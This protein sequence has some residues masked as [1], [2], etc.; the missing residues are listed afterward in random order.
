MKVLIY[1]IIIASVFVGCTADLNVRELDISTDMVDFG[2]VE[3]NKS[4]FKSVEVYNNTQKPLEIQF[5]FQNNDDRDFEL[6]TDGESEIV[7]PDETLRIEIKLRARNLGDKTAKLTLIYNHIG[8]PTKIDIQAQCI[9]HDIQLFPYKESIEFSNSRVHYSSMQILFFKNVGNTDS[10]IESI[11]FASTSCFNVYPNVF[12]I[13]IPQSDVVMVNLYFKPAKAG[14]TE[15][16]MLVKIDSSNVP[17]EIQLKGRGVLPYLNELFPKE[18]FNSASL[19]ANWSI[20]GENNCWE[21]GKPSNGSGLSAYSG[22]YCAG[23]SIASNYPDNS[24]TRLVSPEVDLSQSITP[25]LCFVHWVNT[26]Y[27][28]SG[29]GGFVE[30]RTKIPGTNE[31]SEWEQLNVTVPNYSIEHFND[32]Y[33]GAFG[34]AAEDNSWRQV[35]IDLGAYNGNVI[36]VAWHFQ[37]DSENNLDGWY[38]DDV[39]IFEVRVNYDE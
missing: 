23:T 16:T 33:F 14:I 1:F 5:D 8:S 36:Q 25:V 15:D 7:L 21:V 12:P 9:K 37:S 6:I 35:S 10:S 20:E 2:I 4:S 26:F 19:P 34:G 28:Q 27:D 22:S 32:G 18:S 38:I 3:V 39:Y 24:D 30:I 29:D 17:Y 31:W 13:E 11:T